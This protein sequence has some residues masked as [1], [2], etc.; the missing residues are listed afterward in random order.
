MNRI[1]Q[2][3]L[4][5]LRRRGKRPRPQQPADRPWVTLALAMAALA[6]L[7]ASVALAP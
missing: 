7:L 5:V 1:V 2:A 6:A 4:S 3:P